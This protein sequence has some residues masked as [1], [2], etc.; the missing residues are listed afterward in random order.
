ML[1]PQFAAQYSPK[2][3]FLCKLVL[4]IVVVVAVDGAQ[5][6]KNLKACAL[7]SISQLE[8]YQHSY[9]Q[10]YQPNINIYTA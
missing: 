9:G 2:I 10:S 6:A 7:L 3:H 1:T 8:F 4:V 5:E